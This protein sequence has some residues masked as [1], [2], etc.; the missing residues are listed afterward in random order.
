MSSSNQQTLVA[1]VT[2]AVALVATW[3]VLRSPV[4]KLLTLTRLHLQW[5]LAKSSNKNNDEVDGA[6]SGLFIHPVKSLRAVSLTQVE[7]DAKGFVGDRRYM[8]VY[9]APLP[10]WKSEWGP[11]DTT[12]RFLSQRQCPSL[13]TVVAKLENE[14]LV[15]EWGKNKALSLSLEPPSP[16]QSY[17]AGIWDDQVS[18]DDMG[19]EVATF[20]QVIV[21]ADGN[22][23]AGDEGEADAAGSLYTNVRLVCHSLK[24]RVA[25]PKFTPA[26]ATSWL[27]ASPPVSLTDGF[28]ILIACQTSLDQL[29]ERLVKNGK[30][31][32]PMSRFRPNIVIQ[33][34]ATTTTTT[35]NAA[36][37]PLFDEDTWKTIAIGDQLFAIVKACPRCKQSCTDQETGVVSEEPVSTMKSFRALGDDSDDVFF[38]QNAIPLSRGRIR[39]GDKVR[40]LERGNPVYC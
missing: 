23:K 2:T 30:K 25:N 24:D 11:T 31:S 17:K 19:D 6:V 36:T 39:V 33:N 32:I 10:A 9:P 18:V 26:A 22:C 28:P 14:T 13:A 7:L 37:A 20:C 4:I 5:L 15:L 1:T 29:N 38:A 35:T 21:N 40:V 27:G 8:L 16:K 34:N 12:H 3:H